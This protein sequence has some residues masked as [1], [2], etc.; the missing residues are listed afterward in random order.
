MNF[1]YIFEDDPQKE[2]LQGN[3]TW[4]IPNF[5]M[6]SHWMHTEDICMVSDDRKG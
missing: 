6:P 2:L 1:T 4:S 3:I 5:A